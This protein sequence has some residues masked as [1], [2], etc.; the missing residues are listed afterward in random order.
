MYEIKS[1]RWGIT[2]TKPINHYREALS[3]MRRMG[4]TGS[5][6][7]TVLL[8]DGQEIMQLKDGYLW[9]SWHED[10]QAWYSEDSGYDP[11]AE[12][13]HEMEFTQ[14][15]VTATEHSNIYTGAMETEYTVKAPK[16]EIYRLMALLIAAGFTVN[17]PTKFFDTAQGEGCEISFYIEQLAQDFVAGKDPYGIWS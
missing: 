7:H 11:I 15:A 12:Y 10:A 14:Y 3:V 17:Q 6:V 13:D 2:L 4:Q 5:C 8:K 1:C 16:L 9:L